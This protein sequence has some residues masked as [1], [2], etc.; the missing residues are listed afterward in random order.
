MGASFVLPGVVF[1]GVF[2]AASVVLMAPRPE[3]TAAPAAPIPAPASEAPNAPD[4]IATWDERPARL[5]ATP[6]AQDPHFRNCTDAHAAGRYSI[7]V[8][9]PAYRARMDGDRDGF[10]CE[11]LP[12]ND[13]RRGRM[14]GRVRVLH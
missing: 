6:Q 3:A 1:V 11:P 10:A 5:V 7:P 2:A 9:D 12:V 14:S 4:A 13:R 8:G